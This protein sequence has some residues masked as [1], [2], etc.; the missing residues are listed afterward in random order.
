MLI[1][2]LF[3]TSLLRIEL[4]LFRMRI[5]PLKVRFLRLNKMHFWSTLFVH[6]QIPHILFLILM[7]IMAMV[8]D[9]DAAAIVV[10]NLKEG[11]LWK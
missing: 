6:N 11:K 7:L 4:M 9:M 5:R 2:V 3:L 10:L 8:L 1:L